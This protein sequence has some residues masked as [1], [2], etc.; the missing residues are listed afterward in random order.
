MTKASWLV[1][2]DGGAAADE[3]WVW[4][5]TGEAA[6]GPA[7]AELEARLGAPTRRLALR[8]FLEGLAER[9]DRA[10]FPEWGGR[11]GALAWPAHVLLE[12]LLERGALSARDVSEWLARRVAAVWGAGSA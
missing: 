9:G 8:A 1:Y 6:L 7:R 10:V 4:D 2:G 12:A 11:M 5:Q 3:V